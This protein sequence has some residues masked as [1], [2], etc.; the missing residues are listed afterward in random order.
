MISHLITSAETIAHDPLIGG[1]ALIAFG[2]LVSRMLFKQRPIWRAVAR[3]I[4]LVLLTLLLLYDGIVPHRPL[5]LTG[6][7]YR[8][9][10]AGTLKIAWW[11]W[12]AWFLVALVRAVVIFEGRPRDGKLVQD[13]LSALIYLT[14]AF[15]IIA[16]VFDLPIQ[17]LPAGARRRPR[18]HE[19][20]L[21]PL[22]SGRSAAP[23]CRRWRS[24]RPTYRA[25]GAPL[26][27]KGGSAKWALGLARGARAAFVCDWSD[28]TIL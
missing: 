12:A 23:F 26:H 11:L 20:A 19:W 21:R 4:F 25:D 15:A 9:T 14:A 16:Y 7:P 2:A 3:V 24:L 10:I 13:I 28:P 8:D 18:R 27:A 22:S 17:G 1:S 5:Q 6:A